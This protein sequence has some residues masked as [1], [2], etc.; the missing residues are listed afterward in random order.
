MISEGERGCRRFEIYNS[1]PSFFK[2][3]SYQNSKEFKW[4]L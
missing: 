1:Y 2:D 3:T 4:E